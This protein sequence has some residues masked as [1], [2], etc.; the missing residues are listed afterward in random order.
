MRYQLDDIAAFLQVVE[1]GSISGAATRLNLSKSVVSKRVADLEEALGAELLHRSTRGVQPTDE[2]KRFHARART[3]MEELDRAAEDVSGDEG[4]LAGALHIAAPMTFGTTYLAPILAAFL[5]QHPRLQASFDFDDR[6]VDLQSGHYDLA[7]RI[8]SLPDSSLI[9][10]PLCTSRRVVC[11]SPDY[12]ARAGVPATLD[13]IERHECLGYTNVRSSQAWQF[14]PRQP[15][16]DVRALTVRSRIA[17]NNGEM[18]REACAAGLGLA[19]LPVFIVADA[20][21]DGR[22]IDAMP[23][24]PP[25]PVPIHAVYPKARHPSR[26]VRALVAHLET[27]LDSDPPW[28]RRLSG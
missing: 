13:E 22:L 1:A 15:G 17:A 7:V 4:E 2:G 19:V 9:A 10:R 16:G 28:E 8:A 24:T 14:S 26:K 27:A 20:L 18:L 3:I 11:C 21:A 5:A 12:A 6:Q 25:T 23:D